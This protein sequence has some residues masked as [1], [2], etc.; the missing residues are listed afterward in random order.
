MRIRACLTL[1]A[2]MGLGAPPSPSASTDPDLQT[3]IRLFNEGDFQAAVI[4][5]DRAVE[6]LKPDVASRR[7]EL[8]EAFV[9]KGAALVGLAQEEPAKAAFREALRYDPKRRLSE[10]VFS[11]RVVRV[12]E[13]AREGKSESVLMPPSTAAKKAG[14][15][16]LGI[17]AIVGGVALAGGGVALASQ[18]GDTTPATATP[19][20][21][22]AVTPTQH[23]GPFDLGF[24]SA[25]PAPG[26]TVAGFAGTFAF[27]DTFKVM[28]S[29]ANPTTT[30]AEDCTAWVWLQ[31]GRQYQCGRN[32]TASSFRLAAGQ[33]LQVEIG[34][35]A[36]GGGMMQDYP[37]P[38]QLSSIAVTTNCR[39]GPVY[40][41][42][43]GNTGQN[44]SIYY[45]INP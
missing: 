25:Q 29:V 18:G 16:A 30:D 32:S 15:G 23:Y 24:L 31:A 42:I 28:V 13:A 41:N 4:S 5:L 6:R 12:F 10:V 14:I 3:G 43:P 11:R 2:A 8:A 9:Y 20:L 38:I 1:V 26:S 17:G 44:W 37:T 33:S 7:N 40:S 22:T 34:T 21:S 39:T 45:Q 19:A 35:P 27:A 36:S